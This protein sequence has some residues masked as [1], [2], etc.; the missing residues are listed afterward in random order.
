MRSP[1]HPSTRSRR[2]GFKR[3]SSS[4]RRKCASRCHLS[5]ECASLNARP[6]HAGA[7]PIQSSSRPTMEGENPCPGM[8]SSCRTRLLAEAIRSPLHLTDRPNC[9]I[10]P[11]T[12]LCVR[13]SSGPRLLVCRHG[14]RTAL[15]SSS[16]C[17]RESHDM[18][19]RTFESLVTVEQG[20]RLCALDVDECA[21]LLD[22]LVKR[23]FLTVR[24]D[25]R[26][27]RASDSIARD[28]PMRPAKASLTPIARSADTP[29]SRRAGARSSRD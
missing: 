17:V 22:A 9:G 1:P 19:A 15:R 27:L 11:T 6:I 5:M 2:S 28:V 4:S 10:R 13:P 20:A 24:A 16:A 3:A 12:K 26:Y 21:A 7:N 8:F 18:L 23:K 14:G 25:G 29:V